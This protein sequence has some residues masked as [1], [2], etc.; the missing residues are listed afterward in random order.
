MT[1]NVDGVNMDG[2]YHHG[3]LRTALIQAAENLLAER[4]LEHFSLREV[5]RRAGV[6]PAAPK[7]HFRDT[8]ALLTAIA[9]R[10]FDDLATRLEASA[11]GCP[12]DRVLRIRA[13]GSA[14][15]RFALDERARF[16]LMWR[17]AL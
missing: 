12:G 3:D 8:R 5:A 2:R 16:D 4:G 11:Q 10:A 17:T 7:H 9:V 13:Q 1:S 15:V 6:S 14:Y